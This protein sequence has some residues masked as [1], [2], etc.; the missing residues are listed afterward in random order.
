VLPNLCGMFCCVVYAT[1]GYSILNFLSC[2]HRILGEE[3]SKGIWVWNDLG[4]GV[5][6][7]GM[8]LEYIESIHFKPIYL[9]MN[10]RFTIQ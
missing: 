3:R 6:G 9:N 2:C 10:T 7:I 1:S 5:G 8:G 4:G